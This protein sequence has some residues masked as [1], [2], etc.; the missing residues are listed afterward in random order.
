MPSSF[1]ILRRRTVL[2]K[3][4]LS[5]KITY[6]TIIKSCSEIKDDRKNSCFENIIFQARI[7]VVKRLSGKATL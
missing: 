5:T 3:R 7:F 6:R 2:K 4:S 1:P